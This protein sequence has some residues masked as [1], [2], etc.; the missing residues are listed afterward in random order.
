MLFRSLGTVSEVVDGAYTGNLVGAVLHGPEKAIAVRA[1]AE[2]EGIDLAASSAYSDSA[3]DLPLLEC[4]GLPH[5]VNPDR[6]LKRIAR[7]RGWPVYEFRSAR[8]LARWSSRQLSV[9]S[10]ILAAMLAFF[11]TR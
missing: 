1:L 11:A 9:A 6:R 5:V 4:V 2:R 8:S 3:N 7:Q 10:A